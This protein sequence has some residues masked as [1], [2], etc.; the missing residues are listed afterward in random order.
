VNVLKISHWRVQKC[1]ANFNLIYY[2]A[3]K[4]IST[5]LSAWLSK[6]IRFI[7]RCANESL[8]VMLSQLNTFV[9]ECVEFST[10]S[11][12]CWA[13]Q[14][15]LSNALQH[16]SNELICQNNWDKFIVKK[17]VATF[18]RVQK[19]TPKL[20]NY[21]ILMTYFVIS[22]TNLSEL[23]VCGES[24]CCDIY[25]CSNGKNLICFACVHKWAKKRGLEEKDGK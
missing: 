4:T 21:S 3:L 15:W 23:L 13:N 5:S 1:G 2:D 11:L 17:F 24:S 10:F 7:M 8:F 19:T 9:V 20:A 25:I 12:N 14:C 16:R 18:H 22:E 6:I